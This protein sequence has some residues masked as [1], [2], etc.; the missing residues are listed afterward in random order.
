MQ[1]GAWGAVGMAA[2]NAT[3]LARIQRSG[4]GVIQPAA[5]LDLLRSLLSAGVQGA[6]QVLPL[7]KCVVPDN[8]LPCGGI[9]NSNDEC[10]M[11]TRPQSNEA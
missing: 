10:C 3:A 1:W 4:M 6:P 11:V 5:G 2:Q 9:L 8:S 7:C